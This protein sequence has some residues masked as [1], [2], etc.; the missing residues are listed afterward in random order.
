MSDIIKREIKVLRAKH[1]MTQKD[2]A[3][4]AG[5]SLNTYNRWETNADKI[6]I[7]KLNLIFGAFGTTFEEYFF[8]KEFDETS[9]K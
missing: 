8:K 7:D 4:K 2:V 3:D 5:V 6:P 1:G 9:N